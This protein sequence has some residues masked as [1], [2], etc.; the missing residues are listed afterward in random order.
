MIRDGQVNC[1]ALAFIFNE[2]RDA[3]NRDAVPPHLP[4]IGLPGAVVRGAGSVA[5]TSSCALGR[6]TDSIER[7]RFH[8]TAFGYFV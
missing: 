7:C 5:E 8:S 2:N 3:E 6:G 1:Q 4:I